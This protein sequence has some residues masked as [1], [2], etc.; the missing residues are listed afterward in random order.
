M[1]IIDDNYIIRP[2]E[3]IFEACKGFAADLTD[4]GLEFQPGKL[5]CYIAEEFCNTEWDSLQ[6]DIPNGLITDAHGNVTFG[7]T[8]CNVPIGSKSFIKAYLA[9]KGTH[10]WRGFNV[11]EHLLHPRRWPFPDIPA[12]QMLWILTPVCLQFTGDYWI[13]HVQLDYTI[14]FA[15]SIDAGVEQLF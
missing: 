12:Q 3:D 7:L 2:K 11:I 13:R 4:V 6:G 5:A 8:L 9:R 14:E 10:I 15:E 1:A